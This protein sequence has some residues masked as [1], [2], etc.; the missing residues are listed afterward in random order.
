VSLS[1]LREHNVVGQHE[2][3]LDKN[4]NNKPVAAIVIF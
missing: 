4:N 1:L 2:E 3:V